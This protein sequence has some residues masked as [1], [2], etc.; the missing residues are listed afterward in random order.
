MKCSVIDLNLKPT[1]ESGDTNNE[2][3]YITTIWMSNEKTMIGISLNFEI[4]AMNPSNSWLIVIFMLG[5][6]L[7]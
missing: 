4:I 3:E 7:S 6:S 1:V 5:L 2:I